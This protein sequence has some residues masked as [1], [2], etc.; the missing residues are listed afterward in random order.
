MSWTN[1]KTIGEPVK[2]SLRA[3]RLFHKSLKGWMARS[4]QAGPVPVER[5]QMW[6]MEARRTEEL[7]ETKA[8]IHPQYS[9]D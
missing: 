5:R 7:P 2:R 4:M 1:T 3:L 8:A 9:G 6:L